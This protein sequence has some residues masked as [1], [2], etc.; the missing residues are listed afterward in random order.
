VGAACTPRIQSLHGTLT[1]Y[2]SDGPVLSRCIH[3]S[4]GPRAALSQ[5]PTC[6]SRTAPP[7]ASRARFTLQVHASGSSLVSRLCCWPSAA[8]CCRIPPRAAAVARPASRPTEVLLAAH[9]KRLFLHAASGRA[10]RSWWRPGRRGWSPTAVH[11]ACRLA[12]AAPRVLPGCL[13]CSTPR[14][15]GRQR[16]AAAAPEGVGVPGTSHWVTRWVSSSSRRWPPCPPE[17]HCVRCP[18]GRA[19]RGRTSPVM[20]RPVPGGGSSRATRA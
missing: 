6:T 10:Q 12:G 15:C 19:P 1:L 3:P 14:P 16:V 11:P 2:S 8:A 9:P 20:H 18:L 13:G 4:G 5:P 7:A 17:K